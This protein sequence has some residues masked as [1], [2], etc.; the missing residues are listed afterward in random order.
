[1]LPSQQCLGERL[2]CP[3]WGELSP[4]LVHVCAPAAWLD[5]LGS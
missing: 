1:M 4:F 3:S 5:Y 2:T